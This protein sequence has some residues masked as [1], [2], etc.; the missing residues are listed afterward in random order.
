MKRCRINCFFFVLSALL[1][2]SCLKD[3]FGE[4]D[5]GTLHVE[6]DLYEMPCTGTLSV[7]VYEG[8]RRMLVTLKDCTLVN[9]DVRK[10]S[11]IYSTL[12][13]PN[14]TAE[15]RLTGKS[16]QGTTAI[17]IY[18]ERTTEL[19]AFRLRV[20]TGYVAMLI[21]ES[22]HPVLTANSPQ[23]LLFIDGDMNAYLFHIST[24]SSPSKLTA[25]DLR[26]RGTVAFTNL[27]SEPIMQIKI[28]SVNQ[29][30]SM[31]FNSN[32]AGSYFYHML[33]LDKS[34][35]QSMQST[36]IEVPKDP[37]IEL[38]GI[39]SDVHIKAELLTSLAI[40]PGLL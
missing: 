34:L 35:T 11:E 21:T 7:P 40:P 22:N 33:G 32:P 38:K 2:T 24:L 20:T 13:E 5:Y 19:V 17:S 10:Y 4:Y 30:L 37:V 16:K 36:N 26:E 14:Q 18:D 3:T 29:V 6:R 8:S 39:D 31:T 15:L 27:T 28:E 9:M 23:A 12:W 25:A 1:F